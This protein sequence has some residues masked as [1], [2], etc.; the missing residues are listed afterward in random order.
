MK[1]IMLMYFEENYVLKKIQMRFKKIEATRYKPC[2]SIEMWS[3]YNRNVNEIPMQQKFGI[4]KFTVY[5]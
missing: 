1:C 3:I 5:Y 4:T 2:F